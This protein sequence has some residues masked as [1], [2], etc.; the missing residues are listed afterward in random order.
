MHNFSNELLL[1][2][3]KMCLFFMLC[4][5][6]FKLHKNLLKINTYV[7]QQNKDKPKTKN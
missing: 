1:P 4:N 7:V 2:D 3:I 6:F 5:D